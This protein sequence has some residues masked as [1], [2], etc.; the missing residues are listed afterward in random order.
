MKRRTGSSRAGAY[1]LAP[2][3]AGPYSEEK[4]QDFLIFSYTFMVEHSCTKQYPNNQDVPPFNRFTVP[5]LL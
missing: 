1:G 4:G 3:I 2:I 5:P